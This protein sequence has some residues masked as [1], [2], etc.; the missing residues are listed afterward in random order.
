MKEDTKGEW[1][2]GYIDQ[3]NEFGNFML[4]VKSGN[5]VIAICD[6]DGWGKQLKEQRLA[7]AHLIASSPRMVEFIRKL[8]KQGNKEASDFL[9]TLDLS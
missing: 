1:T 3:K 7:N 4:T 8:A 6:M 5:Q 2:I 9:Q